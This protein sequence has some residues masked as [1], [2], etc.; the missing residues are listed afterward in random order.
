MI[1]VKREPKRFFCISCNDRESE[2]HDIR[3]G[4]EDNNKTVITLCPK[5]L[6]DL[7]NEIAETLNY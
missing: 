2:S 1:E 4:A 7:Y 6:D 3:I 5:C